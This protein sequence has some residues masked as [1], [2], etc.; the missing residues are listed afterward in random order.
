MQ[1][2]APYLMTF[3]NPT[4]PYFDERGIQ[5]PQPSP[6]DSRKRK[7]DELLQRA[8]AAGTFD[9]EAHL[10]P[11]MDGGRYIQMTDTQEWR[12]AG[13][14]GAHNQVV[15]VL[16]II[17]ED[18]DNVEPMEIPIA[19]I[20]TSGIKLGDIEGPDGRPHTSCIAESQI[21][22]VSDSDE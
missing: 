16:D 12:G 7:R 19:D 11:K 6:S 4:N 17:D 2:S 22:L 20:L 10:E 9:F 13:G 21:V 18:S 15:D 8:V 1:V 3:K 14:S 5:R